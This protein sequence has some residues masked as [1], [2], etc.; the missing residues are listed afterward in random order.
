MCVKK[1]QQRNGGQRDNALGFSLLEAIVCIG[2]LGVVLA[3]AIPALQ[4]I[5]ESSR[6]VFCQSTMR[7]IGIA[8]ANFST[9][10]G[11]I[12]SSGLS[13][14]ETPQESNFDWNFLIQVAPYH[15]AYSSQPDR[16]YF[17]AEGV[18]TRLDWNPFS[19]SYQCPSGFG[20]ETLT[21]CA[22]K[23]SGEEINELVLNTI[24][25]AGNGGFVQ[26][27]PGNYELSPGGIDVFTS[28]NQLHSRLSSVTDGLAHT[29]QIWESSSGKLVDQSAKPKD[30]NLAAPES[31][32]MMFNFGKV[33][34]KSEGRASSKTYLYSFAGIRVGA[35]E[36][37]HPT[38]AAG[39][40]SINVSNFNSDPFSLHPGGVNM[41]FLDGSTRFLTQ[42][43]DRHTLTSICTRN[44]SD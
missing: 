42:S 9:T 41:V 39:T 18:Q 24:D 12:P 13:S 38:A 7:Q 21:G 23:F 31:F 40:Q 20:K 35:I 10:K 8:S 28:D 27:I 6:Q 33:L 16:F 26:R 11:V 34:A 30:V 1:N 43:V 22:N 4:A 32:Y 44:R 29:V 25:Y 19:N 5:R 15:D 37:L 2:I 14:L 3:I 17:S 36:S